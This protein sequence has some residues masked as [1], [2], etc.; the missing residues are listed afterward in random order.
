MTQTNRYFIVYKN[1]RVVA[2]PY[3]SK[4][5]AIRHLRRIETTGEYEFEVVD[6]A[7]GKIE[8]CI[9]KLSPGDLIIR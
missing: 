3:I 7:T 5:E 8:H 1:I 9:E 4:E 2:G 6:Q